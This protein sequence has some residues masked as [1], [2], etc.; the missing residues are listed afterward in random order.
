M[1]KLTK[2]KSIK[3]IKTF[4][5][6]LIAEGATFHPDDRDFRKYIRITTGD[7]LYNNEEALLRNRL[8]RECFKICK[9]E[10]TSMYDLYFEVFLKET[11]LKKLVLK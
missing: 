2:V 3:D 10:K 1:V 7:K 8:L 5:S 4:T 6:Q 9:K 11:G